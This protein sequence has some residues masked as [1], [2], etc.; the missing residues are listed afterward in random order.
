MSVEYIAVHIG[1]P[2]GENKY[3]AADPSKGQRHDDVR[4]T[5]YRTRCGRKWAIS[6]RPARGFANIMHLEQ[7]QRCV[8]LIA[9]ESTNG[10]NVSLFDAP[11]SV[12]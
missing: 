9:G 6:A 10:S 2:W 1:S 12:G 5:Y 4:E 3:H 11:G 8:H 7:C